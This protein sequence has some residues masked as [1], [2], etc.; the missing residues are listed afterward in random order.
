[1]LKEKALIEQ[2]SGRYRYTIRGTRRLGISPFGLDSNVSEHDS[3]DISHAGK[4]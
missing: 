4:I 1:M 2:E 3:D